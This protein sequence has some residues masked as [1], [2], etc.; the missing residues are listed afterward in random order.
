MGGLTEQPTPIQADGGIWKPVVIGVAV[1]VVVVAVIAIVS[2]KEKKTTALP[3]GYAANLQIGDLK[4]SA[5]EKPSKFPSA[6]CR[7]LD[8][9][10]TQWI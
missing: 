9:I 2:R 6:S 7:P 1:V 3:P 8:L 5:A 10:P 4:M